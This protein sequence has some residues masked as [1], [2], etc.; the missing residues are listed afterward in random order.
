MASWTQKDLTAPERRVNN[1]ARYDPLLFATSTA[2]E[3]AEL[4]STSQSTVA[5]TAQKLG[6]PG[7]REMKKEAAA[8]V[9]HS[10]SLRIAIKTR[11][12]SIT[13]AL[14]DDTLAS[15]TDV[16]LSGIAETIIN[17]SESL[18]RERLSA[19][20]DRMTCANRTVIFGLGTAGSI[21]NYLS[22]ELKRA[23][24]LSACISAS[25]HSL[26]DEILQLQKTDYVLV[27]APLRVFPEIKIFIDEAS[28]RADGV[29]LITQDQR[30]V[31]DE[32]TINIIQLP[33]TTLTTTSE[34][35]A[36]WVLADVLIAN[37]SSDNPDQAIKTR[38]NTLEL[39][40]LLGS[41]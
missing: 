12:Q 11:I 5:R 24:F 14:A 41:L 35:A 17:F 16:V 39:R 4:A 22:I 34:S 23:G 6:F 15:T 20:I 13:D 36:A 38:N 2:N 29:S 37:L 18:N 9:D 31:V 25:G 26:A 30:D 8:R 3:I 33:T 32:P 27:F 1:L 21:A 28:K 19:L 7:L 10:S 40:N